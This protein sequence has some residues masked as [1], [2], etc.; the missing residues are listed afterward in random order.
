MST[1]ESG[2][3][4]KDTSG[5][6]P[7]LLF[8]DYLIKPIQRICKY[9][10]LLKQ[11][12][13]STPDKPDAVHHDVV[14]HAVHVMRAVTSSVNEA[15]RQQTLAVKSSLV[16]TRLSQGVSTSAQPSQLPLTPVFLSSLGLCRLAG[17]LDV[18]HYHG[19]TWRK[20]T[21]VK[22]KYLGA[23]LFSGGFF[24]LAKVTKPKS[25][26]P[27]H[28]FN[29]RGVELVDSNM[30]DGR[31]V[32]DGAFDHG[33]TPSCSPAT[34]LVSAGFQGTHVRDRS[35]LS[36]RE[37]YLDERYPRCCFRRAGMGM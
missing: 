25:Y 7:R 22:A 16:I 11:L 35:I 28:W 5:R 17:S 21:T 19:S 29:L 34:E 33:L 31:L 8:M 30:D 37:G 36:P 14:R 13:G 18:I 23:F 10:L 3:S 26:E 1:S 27:R 2:H 9:P 15:R 4:D 12:Q 6:R 20:S 32:I 24:I